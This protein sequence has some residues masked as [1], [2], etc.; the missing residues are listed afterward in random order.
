MRLAVFT[1]KYPARVA[2]FFERD[3][4]AL[5][6]VGVEIDVFSIYPLDR[7]LWRYSLDIMDGDVLPR[8]RLHHI[9]LARSLWQATPWRPRGLGLVLREGAAIGMAAARYGLGPLAKSLYVLPKAWAWA[10][11]HATGYDHVLAYW[12]NYAGSC[13]YLFHRLIDRPIPFSI[14]LHAGT[15]LYYRPIYLRQKLRYADSI[16]T[17]CEFNRAYI[18]EHYGD[19]AP[20]IAERVHVCY[21]GLDLSGFPYRPEGRP[22]HRI[23]AV[24]RLAKDKGFGYLLQ[25]ARVLV[26]RGLDLEIDIVGDGDQLGAL[27]ALAA[28]LGIADRVRFRGWLAFAEVRRAMSEATVLVHPSD[29]LGDGLP[30]VLREAMALGTPVIASRVAGIP[31]ALDD[32]RCGVLVPP[33]DVA[34]LASALERLL[35]DAALRQTLARRAR[36][37]TEEKFD[38]WHNGAQLAEHLRAI[39]RLAPAARSSGDALEPRADGLRRRARPPRTPN[40]PALPG[41]P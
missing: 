26:D 10:T 40:T 1:S 32:G 20:G 13:A 39:R 18:A 35:G 33:R 36:Q 12:G 7:G 30:N 15:D 9:G 23:I 38:M 25:A 24:G 31:E 19:A 28:G 22:P 17:C 5:L 3:M 4:R 29:G 11:Q 34:A 21:H 27:R 37:R 16:I 6:E 41:A 8:S 2:T 14:W